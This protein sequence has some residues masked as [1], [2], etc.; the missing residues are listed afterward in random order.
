MRAARCV[1]GPVPVP[2]PAW[3][4]ASAVPT[5]TAPSATSSTDRSALHGPETSDIVSGSVSG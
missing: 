3:R 2:A 4:I 5:P 1:A